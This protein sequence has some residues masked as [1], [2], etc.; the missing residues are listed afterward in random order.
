VDDR[1]HDRLLGPRAE[2]LAAA[3]WSLGWRQGGDERVTIGRLPAQTRLTLG[4][5]ERGG[6]GVVITHLPGAAPR[7]EVGV[8]PFGLRGAY[9]SECADGT[10]CGSLPQL[11]RSAGGTGGELDAQAIHGY[12]CFSYV[13]HPLT[14]FKDVRALGAGARWTYQAGNSETTSNRDW[15]ERAAG[16]RELDGLPVL[17]R[18]LLQSVQRSL[19]DEKEAAVFLSGGLDS[20]LIAALLGSL[21][22]RVH[23]LT[24]D[25]GEPY[26]VEVEFA[27][28][29]AA[30][31]KLPLRRVPAGPRE[32]RSALGP[33][34]SALAQPFGDGVT[35]PLYLLG[36]AA[37]EMCGLIFNGE[38]GDQLFGGWANK[39][40]LA[41]ELYGDTGN[42]R[43]ATYLA[44]YHRFLG[45]TDELYS[46]RAKALVGRQD[47][48][49]WIRVGLNPTGFQSLLH[50]LRAANLHLKG[51][52]NIAPRCVQL[53]AAHGLRA[54]TPFF[55]P[56]LTDWTFT[57]SPELLLAGSTE[58]HLLKLV[59]SRYLP[60]RI[61][62]REKR[63]MGV[64]LTDWL[65]GPLRGLVRGR[66][67]PLR[68]KRD[69]WFDPGF[70]QRLSARREPRGDLRRRRTGEKLWAL[71]MLHA[72]ID[73]QDPPLGFPK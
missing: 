21:G 69:G 14:A 6:A 58:K 61:V 2:L 1:P 30:H 65:E 24:L 16:L 43:E 49:K 27:E 8:D 37:A 56:A 73:A 57:L 40:V 35:V 46:P 45:E 41:S 51:A 7:V 71:L 63:G 39:P 33:T 72:W 64:P 17:E 18:L 28:E 36:K 31:L 11:V 52:Q 44:T 22:V 60:A 50:R 10:R 23:L 55:D 12:L 48:G 68:L 70:V 13:P 20:S 53:A 15:R 26:N 38:G 47:E 67:S 19:G 62:W 4:D 3:G 66:L 9:L 42:A 25:F 34:A 29:V 32:V 59:A 5:P 54:A